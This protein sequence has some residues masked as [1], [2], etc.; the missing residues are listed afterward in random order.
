MMISPFMDRFERRERILLAGPDSAAFAPL[1][2]ELAR[3]GAEVISATEIDEA[4]E[5][6]AGPAF[7]AVYVA[8]RT[9]ADA[10]LLLMRLLQG[11]A[12]GARLMLVLEA[13]T[14][15][16]HGAALAL[17]EEAM[18]FALSPSRLA[19]AAG[20]GFHREAAFA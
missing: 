10:T 13:K 14:A 19:D 16:L 4:A 20:V 6:M 3:R 15:S 1:S 17:A 8:G 5:A 9:S 18:T 12:K 7:D 2:A 11:R